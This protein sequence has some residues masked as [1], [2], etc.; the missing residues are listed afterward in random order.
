MPVP[1]QAWS[2]SIATAPPPAPGGPTFRFGVSVRL[3]GGSEGA[4]RVETVEELMAIC[5]VLQLP[6]GQLLFEPNGQTLIKSA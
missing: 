3:Q 6:G 5:A 1:V 4:L 2:I